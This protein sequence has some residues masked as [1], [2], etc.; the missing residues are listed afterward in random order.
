[1]TKIQRLLWGEDGQPDM[2]DI[3]AIIAMLAFTGF[4]VE[5]FFFGK[6]LIMA[7]VYG[8]AGIGCGSIMSKGLKFKPKNNGV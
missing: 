6:E 3:I 4:F 2:R 7:N 5:Y 1:M 8:T